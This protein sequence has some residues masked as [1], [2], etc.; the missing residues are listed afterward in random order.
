MLVPRVIR[1]VDNYFSHVNSLVPLV[2]LSWNRNGALELFKLSL[3]IYLKR[4]SSMMPVQRDIILFVEINWKASKLGW[5]L[6][7]VLLW[8]WIS[9]TRDLWVLSSTVSRRCSSLFRVF[10]REVTSLLCSLLP[11]PAINARRCEKNLHR[12]CASEISLREN[13]KRGC[14]W[15]FH[16]WI[17]RIS[18]SMRRAEIFY[19]ACIPIRS[20][21]PAR[22]VTWRRA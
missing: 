4:R 18:C 22:R 20:W 6:T 12:E 11:S 1:E 13:V 9:S 8:A 17:I 10:L 14:A 3:F 15:Y 7:S 5:L 21:Q 2:T 19:R 16:A